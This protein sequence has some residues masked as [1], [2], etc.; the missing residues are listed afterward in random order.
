MSKAKGSSAGPVYVVSVNDAFVM[1]AWQESLDPGKASGVRFLADPEG[2][3]VNELDLLFDATG[4]L[5]NKRAQRFAIVVKDGKVAKFDV[6][7]D[8]TQVTVTSAD[9]LL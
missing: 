6:E 2:K 5:G 9:K 4:L 1:N 8:P 3:F 7:P